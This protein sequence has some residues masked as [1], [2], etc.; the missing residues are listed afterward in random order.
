MK[1]NSK[2][3]I[4]SVVAMRESVTSA[5]GKLILFGEHAVV[6]GRKGIAT[7]INLRTKVS[8]IEYPGNR[9]HLTRPSPF[10]PISFPICLLETISENILP[11]IE[12][13]WT[14]YL[15]QITSILY[16]PE[17]HLNVFT[18]LEKYYKQ[19]PNETPV[20]LESDLGCLS[21]VLLFCFLLVKS[22]KKSKTG[23]KLESTSNLPMG[24]GLGSSAAYHVA[25]AGAFLKISPRIPVE[26][27]N[28]ERWQFWSNE[29]SFALEKIV[30][31]PTA[32]GID[33]MISVYGGNLI[34]Q[35]KAA[36]FHPV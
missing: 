2:K 24:A 19:N 31:G 17:L 5:P 13:D 10:L 9:F 6:Y 32:S 30:H 1:I 36:T 33:N 20:N 15:Q 14:S 18:T 35:K 25:L 28:K 8:I 3:L 4:N 27:L 16:T 7:A 12:K 21:A 22:S 26:S 34:Y 11:I 29:I 23:W